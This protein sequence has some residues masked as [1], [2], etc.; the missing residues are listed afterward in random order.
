MAE[1]ILC[2]CAGMGAFSNAYNHQRDSGAGI[3]ARS[4]PAI[5]TESSAPFFWPIPVGPPSA[6]STGPVSDPYLRCLTSSRVNRDANTQSRLATTILPSIQPHMHSFCSPFTA[7][8]ARA[9]FLQSS[10]LRTSFFGTHP[11]ASAP[12]PCTLTPL[13]ALFKS[14]LSRT[15]TRGHRESDVCVLHDVC[16]QH[17]MGSLFTSW[18][19]H[20]NGPSSSRH[21]PALLELCTTTFRSLGPSTLNA[22]SMRCRIC[23][24]KAQMKASDTGGSED[25]QNIIPLLVATLPALSA[26]ANVCWV[27]ARN[28]QCGRRLVARVVSVCQADQHVCNDSH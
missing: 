18:V 13:A 12:N 25:G 10:V 17:S 3:A 22:L 16:P 23:M 24:G 4:G 27:R 8:A 20:L 2:G 6:L 19:R 11:S 7:H 5:R 15:S 14:S 21:G 9:S 28:L 26:F 1:G